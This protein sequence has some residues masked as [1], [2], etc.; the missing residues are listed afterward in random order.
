MT[1]HN[2]YWDVSLK[3][4]KPGKQLIKLLPGFVLF[5]SGFGFKAER[6]LPIDS[7]NHNKFA[8]TLPVPAFLFR[9]CNLKKSNRGKVN[10]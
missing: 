9:F 1:P 7:N 6:S 4:I 2:Y 3:K 10:E 8:A 5:L